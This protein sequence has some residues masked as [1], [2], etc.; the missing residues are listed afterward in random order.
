MALVVF[1]RGTRIKTPASSIFPP[2]RV[3]ASSASAAEPA[4]PSGQNSARAEHEQLI[5]DF[6]HLGHSSE[7]HSSEHQSSEHK[8]AVQAYASNAEQ[9]EPKKPQILARQIM[10]SPV[11]SCQI[12][13]PVT[14]AI[15][16]M[17]TAGVH[18]L[19]VFD[20]QSELTGMV[21]RRDLLASH[22]LANSSVESAIQQH[23]LAATPDTP[24]LQIASNLLEYQCGAVLV[25]D[26]E[27]QL[28]GIITRT[29]LIRL[30]ISQARVEGWV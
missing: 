1:D 5:E 11:I 12:D 22:K 14:Q 26:T 16:Q 3:E 2:R 25:L 15:S 23:F 9:S 21:N 8:A 27:D 4:I 13:T 29:D 7:Q 6:S 20:M 17:E 30:L 24:V 19:A 10:S 28:S 18:Y